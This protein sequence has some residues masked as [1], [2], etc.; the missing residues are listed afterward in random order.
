MKENMHC[1]QAGTYDGTR[2]SEERMY[3]GTRSLKRECLNNTAVIILLEPNQ[4][5]H[6]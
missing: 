2:F 1:R 4:I 6:I 5:Y 3:D